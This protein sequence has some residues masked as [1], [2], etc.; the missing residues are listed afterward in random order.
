[1]T[2]EQLIKRQQAELLKNSLDSLFLLR[3]AITSLTP[4]DARLF[5]EAIEATQTL[6]AHL[7]IEHE[8]PRWI[9]VW[10]QPRGWQFID[11]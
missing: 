7:E 9:D 6:R 4:Q 3:D 11:K 1:M 8:Y 2:T 5:D 10:G